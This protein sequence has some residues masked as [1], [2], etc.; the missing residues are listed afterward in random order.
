MEMSP[1]EDMR[2]FRL[3]PEDFGTQLWKE[4]RT[5]RERVYSDRLDLHLHDSAREAE[6]DRHS[7][8]FGI[9]SHGVLKATIR[10]TPATAPLLEMRELGVFP[11][12][13]TGA[14]DVCEITRFAVGDK[15]L[16]Y[17]TAVVHGFATWMLQNTS[18]KRYYAYCRPRSAQYFVRA[19]GARVLPVT[20]GISERGVTDYRIVTG[21][22]ADAEGLTRPRAAGLAIDHPGSECGF[23]CSLPVG[24]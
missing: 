16:M 14:D 15:G 12:Q 19:F 24:R 1:Q 7:Y 9:S 18:I 20:F 6:I 5:L 11:Q 22:M 13:M 10:L 8:V 2:F 23:P 4:L 21:T 17:G 3:P